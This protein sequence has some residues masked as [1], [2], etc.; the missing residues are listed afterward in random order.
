MS[1][2][3]LL[4]VGS[5]LRAMTIDNDGNLYVG[6][7]RSIWII[8]PTP[9]SWTLY[10]NI[11]DPPYDDITYPTGVLGNGIYNLSV[12]PAGTLYAYSV[13]GVCIIAKG[14]NL[15]YNDFY[16]ANDYGA[17]YNNIYVNN[18][19]MPQSFC[20]TSSNGVKRTKIAI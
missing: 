19:Q 4:K 13:S 1:Y 2:K 10:F 17:M 3:S 14:G 20:F 7:D 11:P 8:Y 16:G 12:D 6:V 9:N 15:L 18:S 5:L